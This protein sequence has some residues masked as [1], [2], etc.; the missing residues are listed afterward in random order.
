MNCPLQKQKNSKY[1][2][3]SDNNE[4]E[5]DDDAAD[6]TD[7]MGFFYNVAKTNSTND[8]SYS[9]KVNKTVLMSTKSR[10]RNSG[11]ASRMSS[12]RNRGE[13]NAIYTSRRSARQKKNDK[14]AFVLRMLGLWLD[15]LLKAL[16]W[17]VSLITDIVW[18]SYGIVWDK[19]CSSYA[20]VRQHYKTVCKEVKSSA[21]LH[22]RFLTYVDR[23][24]V[25]N[26]RWAFWRRLFRRQ[27]PIETSG[28][29]PG[30]AAGQEFYKNGRLPQTGEEAMYSLLN[31]KGKDAY[32]ILGVSQDCSQEQIR[33]HYKKIAVLVHPD[34]NKQPG[35]EEA[36]KVLQ[37]AFE[38]IGEPVSF[39]FFQIY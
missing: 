28:L 30:G 31:C 23:K 17:L 27:P 39:F 9:E 2:H 35:A 18:L 7:Q 38:L 34:K 16:L 26:S 37:R 10:S 22:R 24:F 14:Y 3:L 19:M 8:A 4:D 25:K 15:Y 12:N 33:K 29:G 21:N 20:F 1:N 5:I 32:S 13:S 36:F 6:E 11:S